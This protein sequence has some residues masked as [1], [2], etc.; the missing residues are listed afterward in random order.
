MVREKD[1]S[2]EVFISLGILFIWDLV[3]WILG[4]VVL[5]LGFFFWSGVGFWGVGFVNG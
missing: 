3:K 4:I 2:Y 5:F 1:G